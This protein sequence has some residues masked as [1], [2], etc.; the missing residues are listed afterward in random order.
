MVKFTCLGCGACY[1]VAANLAG[2]SIKCRGCGRVGKVFA[3]APPVPEVEP[4]P[5]SARSSS[6]PVAGYVCPF[7]ATTERWQWRLVWT[8]LSTIG[9]LLVGPLVFVVAGQ[10]FGLLVRSPAA[11]APRGDGYEL[12]VT[13]VGVAIAAASL[14]IVAVGACRK[15]LCERHQVCPRCGTR[16][17]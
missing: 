13:T 5:A 6:P 3:G 2:K 10:L 8:P 9:A 12:L 1:D 16:I 11:G 14:A 15:L 4:L 7:C 17:G